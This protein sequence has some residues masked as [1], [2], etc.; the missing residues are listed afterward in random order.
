MQAPNEIASISSMKHPNFALVRYT[1][2]HIVENG[3]LG[4]T[5]SETS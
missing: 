5:L 1:F 2:K 4:A 3:S